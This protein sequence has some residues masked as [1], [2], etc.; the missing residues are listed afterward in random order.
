MFLG[1]LRVLFREDVKLF[2][3]PFWK[4][5]VM[6]YAKYS[7][8]LYNNRTL[9]WTRYLLVLRHIG[10]LKTTRFVYDFMMSC[11]HVLDVIL[12]KVLA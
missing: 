1:G 6:F 5:C 2:G 12:G 7:A 10:F 4:M 3:G 9:I 8:S 11:A